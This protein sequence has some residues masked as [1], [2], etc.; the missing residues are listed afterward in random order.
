MNCDV[1]TESYSTLHDVTNPQHHHIIVSS[2]VAPTTWIVLTYY[3][4]RIHR[5]NWP[6]RLF[7]VTKLLRAI[8]YHRKVGATP[9]RL[10]VT[11]WLERPHVVILHIKDFTGQSPRATCEKARLV[12]LLTRSSIRLR[13]AFT[14][15]ILLRV[16]VVNILTSVTFCARLRGWRFGLMITRWLRST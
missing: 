7:E 12:S 9:A 4:M 5:Q 6:T 8:A 15:F 10:V 2:S 1:I 13:Q 3:R 11:E 14:L 16:T